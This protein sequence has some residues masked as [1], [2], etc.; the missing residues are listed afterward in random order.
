MQERVWCLHLTQ[1]TPI[2]SMQAWCKV[3]NL[4]LVRRGQYENE[5][6]KTMLNQKSSGRLARVSRVLI[7]TMLCSTFLYQGW[8]KP[9]PAEAAI[10]YQTPGAIA[11][12]AAA[13]TTVAP[14]YPAGIA[15]NDLLVMIVGMK[16]ST[17][18]S[19]SVTTPAG[20]TPIVS[21]IGAG[22]YGAVLAAD[23]G[24]TN[25]FA[26]YKVAA[27]TE[28][29]SLTVTIATNNISWAQMYRL[30][31]TK[32]SWGV[33]GATGSDITG[34]AAVSIAFSSDPGVAANDFILGAMCIP[35][36][37]TTPAQF[38]VEAFAQTGATFG[39]VTEISEP[40]SAIGNQIGGFVISAAVSAGT[41]SAAPTMTAT[42][43]ATNTNVRGPGVFI[44]IREANKPSTITSCADCHGYGATFTDGTARNTPAGKFPGSHQ[45]HVASYGK[46]CSVCHVAPA[47]ETSD[48]YKHRNGVAQIANPING[49]AGSTYS[50]ASFTQ[51]NSFTPGYCSNT[52]CHS[53]GTSVITSVIPANTSASWGGTTT[54]L[55]CHGVGG[56]DDGRPNYVN[57]TPK[58]NTHGDGASYGVTHK[59]TVCTTCHTGVAGT[60]GAYTISDTTTHN[61][62]AYNLQ[63][64]L[65][66]TQATGVCSTP[67]CHGSA[68]WGGPALTCVECHNGIVSA[69]NASTAS[70][71][72]VTQRDNAVAEFG[73]AWGHKKTGRGAVTVSDC[74]VCHLEGVFATQAKS[75]TYHG[76]GYIDLRAPDVAGETRITDISGTS[77]RFVKFSTSYVAGSRTSTGHTSNNIDN[78]LTQK[79][80]LACHDIDGATNTTARTT[81]GTPTAVRP[82]GGVNLGANYTVVNGAASA[83]GDIVN[84]KSQFATAN[85]SAH[86]VLGPR[87]KDFPTAARMNDPYK[88]AGTRGTSGTLS[89]GVV[90]NCFDCHNAPTPLTART[91]AAHGNAV[92]IPG[93]LTITGTPAAT[94]NQVTF[95][96]VCH[97]GYTES[98]ATHHN[99]GSALDAATR[100][101]MTDYLRYAC[102]ICHSSGWYTAVVQPVR[103]Q[104]VHGS[105]VLPA[106]G[107]TKTVRWSGTS[108]GSPAQVNVR[109]YAFIRNTEVV[110]DHSPRMIGS[111][112]YSA[113][114]NMASTV[115]TLCNQGL[116]VYTVGGTY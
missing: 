15:A 92:T 68:T 22:G 91:V 81:Y 98:T 12:S 24:N 43:A 13:G 61:N 25:L 71:G 17:A 112:V 115:T 79:F 109:P 23:T 16:S 86:P 104:D 66:Y 55:S 33:A 18:N 87:N 97:I 7:F 106:G 35:T 47:T 89:Q 19:G 73:L 90:M 72:T 60:A 26:Y 78:V 50:K 94:T 52:F 44:R 49:L 111:T 105:N 54:C 85:S 8:Y 114:C 75:A 59:A 76:D 45:T 116:K 42:A 3:R 58:R 37:I 46:T 51:T 107:I 9:Q 84:V 36:D 103:A 41:G 99:P 29:G 6:D 113:N 95:C 62:G 67:G 74:I 48:D 77:F 1:V 34:D 31:K 30:S 39:T 101:G 102:N 14:A 82:F 53:N 28:T 96:Q 64:S 70:G 40:D 80:C 20:W 100:A 2:C 38:T 56:A 32:E 93:V 108:T 57:N 21:L 4:L 65:G 63:G 10:T 69:P 27:G 83:T 5:R 11:Y 88:P 110:S